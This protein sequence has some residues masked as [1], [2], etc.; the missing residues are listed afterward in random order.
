MPANRPRSLRMTGH[1]SS[2]R[3]LSQCSDRQEQATRRWA[4]VRGEIPQE[5]RRRKVRNKAIQARVNRIGT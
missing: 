2:D 3:E 1:S 5:K 4:E